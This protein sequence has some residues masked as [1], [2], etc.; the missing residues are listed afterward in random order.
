MQTF[1]MKNDNNRLYFR[2]PKRIPPE[3][4]LKHIKSILKENGIT[5]SDKKEAGLDDIYSCTKDDMHFNIIFTGE[6][7]FLYSDDEGC[8][9]KLEQ[10]INVW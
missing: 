5:I 8:L 10:M 7:T 3:D 1:R 9:E 6:E 2:N 4:E